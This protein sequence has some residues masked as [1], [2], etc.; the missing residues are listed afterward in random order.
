MQATLKT[1]GTTGQGN[2]FI[3][4]TN[5]SISL[6]QKEL[7]RAT[8]ELKNMD[9][10]TTAQ[11]NAGTA[12]AKASAAKAAFNAEQ[13]GAIQIS[14]STGGKKSKT[15]NEIVSTAGYI[16]AQDGS[17]VIDQAKLDAISNKEKRKA[18]ADALNKEINDRIS[19]KNAAED[20]IQKAQEALEKFGQEL[21]E[22]FFGW[23]TE[24]TKIWNLTQKI[25]REEER[26]S[27]SKAYTSLLEAQLSSGIEK[28]TSAFNKD[29]LEA[30]RAEV[31]QESKQLQDRANSIKT[32]QANVNKA[33]ST[34]DE[35]ATLNAINSKLNQN[36]K[37]QKAVET[38]NTKAAAV[39]SAVNRVNAAKQAVANAKTAQAKARKT[40]KTK[41]DKAA[42]TQLKKAQTE[43]N[44]AN[45]AL[46]NARSAYNTA[47][48]NYKN[49]IKSN[50]ALSETEKLGYENY[51]KQLEEQIAAQKA[52]AQYMTTTR[53]ADG[54]I[55]I[56]FNAD[57]LETDKQKG[58][59]TADKVKKIEEYVKGAQ[60]ATKELN[61]AYKEVTESL[62]SMYEKLST[63]QDQWADYAKELWDNMEKKSKQDTEDMKL[64]SNAIADALRQLL[65][66][67]RKALDIMKGKK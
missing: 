17:Y 44:N 9:Y 51:K 41:D 3:Q 4:N 15:K 55:S 8:N 37:V 39:D 10:G 22:T 52:A 35:Q 58:L 32:L 16:K 31:A 57:K 40:K 60:D 43:L 59:L 62:T 20:A 53:Y 54:T 36:T 33:L 34:A 5:K 12:K 18:L 45:K 21:Y 66:K 46:A 25:E 38:A 23:E 63:L 7:D 13:G 1:T 26:I 49:V 14:Y 42:A 28:A 65:D 47:A 29:T 19:K 48:A 11:R 67:V 30:F 56:D 6:Y 24:L 64:I 61:D 2:A 50:N 27:R